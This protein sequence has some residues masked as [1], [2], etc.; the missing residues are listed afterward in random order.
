ML[1]LKTIDFT[2]KT[3]KDAFDDTVSEFMAKHDVIN[4]VL[5]EPY[6]MTI[7]Y[8]TEER[9]LTNVVFR[10]PSI[11]LFNISDKGRDRNFSDRIR[12][13]VKNRDVQKIKFFPRNKHEGMHAVI[14]FNA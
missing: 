4:Y 13:E 12:S 11:N 1:R 9:T 7:Y 3:N 8:N 14:Y 2:D 5:H 6:V 10:E